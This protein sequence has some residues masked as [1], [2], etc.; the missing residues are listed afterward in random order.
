MSKKLGR[1]QT[2]QMKQHIFRMD[3]EEYEETERIAKLAQRNTSQHIREAIR[4]ENNRVLKE[5]K[6]AMESTTGQGTT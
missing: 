3:E 5:Q 4:N 2:G 6:D 1:P